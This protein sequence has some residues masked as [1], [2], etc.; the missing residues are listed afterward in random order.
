MSYLMKSDRQIKLAI[1]LL[2]SG[3]E[4]LLLR[5]LAGGG[6]QQQG[7][8]RGGQVSGGKL[9]TYFSNLKNVFE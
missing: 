7:R 3:R 6:R 5:H 1:Q 4:R 9:E 8:E 2:C